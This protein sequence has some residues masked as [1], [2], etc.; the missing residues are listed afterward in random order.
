MLRHWG[1]AGAVQVKAPL[2]ED[3]A[4]V[5]DLVRHGLP[6]ETVRVGATVTVAE[7]TAQ[8]GDESVQLRVVPVIA[9]HSLNI[10]LA[11]RQGPR[12]V[13]QLRGTGRVPL[14]I[15]GFQSLTRTEERG[16]RRRQR[17]RGWR[18]QTIR[19]ELIDD[20]HFS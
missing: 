20:E 18:W 10:A 11:T 3:R 4:A 7:V 9:M 17:A 16:G 13:D 15:T 14:V 2:E 19:V 1:R 5:V 12:E 6:V 8:L